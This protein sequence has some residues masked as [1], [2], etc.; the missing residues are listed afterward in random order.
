MCA[1]YQ[2]EKE[3]NKDELCNHLIELISLASQQTGLVQKLTGLMYELQVEKNYLMKQA[4][5][6]QNQIQAG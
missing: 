4:Q 6:I 3:E 5:A 1:Y 2:R